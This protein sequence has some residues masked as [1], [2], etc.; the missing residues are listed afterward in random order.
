MPVIVQPQALWLL[1]NKICAQLKRAFDTLQTERATQK[2]QELGGDFERVELKRVMPKTRETAR[3]K[4]RAKR[5]PT[6]RARRN[7]RARSQKTM[8]LSSPG[9][10]ECEQE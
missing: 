10:K 6:S 7:P 5:N 3:R 4:P 2:L 8:Y 1:R 9:R